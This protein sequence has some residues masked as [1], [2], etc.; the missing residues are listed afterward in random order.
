[1]DYDVKISVKLHIPLFTE[2][3]LFCSC[4]NVGGAPNTN[5]CSICLGKFG[6]T[7]YLNNSATLLAVLAGVALNCSVGNKIVFDKA[8]CPTSCIP[9]G[10]RI[11]Q[12]TAPIAKKGYI[13]ILKDNKKKRIRIRRCR[14]EEGYRIDEYDVNGERDFNNCGTAV[15]TIESGSDLVSGAEVKSYLNGIYSLMHYVGASNCQ[16]GQPD[17]PLEIKI[18]VGEKATKAV[19]TC[20]L[21]KGSPDDAEFAVDFE[22]GRQIGI[23]DSKQKVKNEKITFDKKTRC[24]I[25]T[26]GHR[27]NFDFDNTVP[28]LDVSSSPAEIRD[29]YLYAV[30]SIV[31]ELPIDKKIRYM[32]KFGVNE[33]HADIISCEKS[34]AKLFEYSAEHCQYPSECAYWIADELAAILKVGVIPPQALDINEERFSALMNLYCGHLIDVNGCREILMQM[35]INGVE[36][37]YYASKN[38]LLLVIDTET[39]R[40]ACRLALQK[41]INLLREYLTGNR[42][43]FEMLCRLGCEELCGRVSIDKLSGIMSQEATVEFITAFDNGAFFNEHSNNKSAFEISSAE[44]ANELIRYVESIPNEEPELLIK[45]SRILSNYQIGLLVDNIVKRAEQETAS[46][47]AE[48]EAIEINPNYVDARPY[49]PKSSPMTDY[50]LYMKPQIPEYDEY[51]NSDG[52]LNNSDNQNKN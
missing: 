47:N 11:V 41:N 13:D 46:A 2:S 3:K 38:G 35:I 14:L 37:F 33:S 5:V 50:F 32:K 26:T 25:P 51:Y 31:G 34:F 22:I 16:P 30:S 12:Y 15:L 39:I 7:P 29:I 42:Q 28:M 45:K 24:T 52:N 43:A 48:K 27:F 36:P 40:T 44:K 19:G 23:L 4:K 10:Y 8:V 21:M 9:K 18:S 49:F 17:I 20:L 6:A 1:M